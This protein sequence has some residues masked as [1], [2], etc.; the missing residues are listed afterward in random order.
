MSQKL[1]K[2]IKRRHG[3]H[4]NRQLILSKTR[5]TTKTRVLKKKSKTMQT[6]NMKVHTS[7]RSKKI[8]EITWGLRDGMKAVNPKS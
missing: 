8:G 6:T 2:Q 7:N 3:I 5:R 4:K 1:N